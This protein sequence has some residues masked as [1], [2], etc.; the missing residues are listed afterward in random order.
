[1]QFFNPLLLGVIVYIL[2]IV[3]WQVGDEES[4]DGG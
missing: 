4:T 3:V 1:M 2:F